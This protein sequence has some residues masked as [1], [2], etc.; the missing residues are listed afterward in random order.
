MDKNIA[1][2]DSDGTRM[3]SRARRDLLLGLGAL[4][5]F[6]ALSFGVLGLFGATREPSSGIKVQRRGLEEGIALSVVHTNDTWGYLTH[7]GG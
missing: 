1:E 3:P 4:A 7:C 6:I 2:H 5:L